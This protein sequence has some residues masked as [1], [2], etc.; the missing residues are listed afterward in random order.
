M[1]INNLDPCIIQLSML[2][3][4][5][6][7]DFYVSQKLR[8]TMLHQYVDKNGSQEE[9]EDLRSLDEQIEVYKQ[10]FVKAVIPVE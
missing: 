4:E 10:K 7:I 2:F 3:D 5:L 6:L 9:I 8:I 1:T